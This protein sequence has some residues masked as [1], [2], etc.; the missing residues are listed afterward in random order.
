MNALP[1]DEKP[2]K[3]QTNTV[4]TNVQTNNYYQIFITVGQLYNK[5]SSSGYCPYRRSNVPVVTPTISR[6]VDVP[7]AIF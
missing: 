7:F 3:V 5:I 2:M 1:C 6:T 4:P